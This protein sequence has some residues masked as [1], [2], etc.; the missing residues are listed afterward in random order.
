MPIG[1]SGRKV[2]Y[3]EV[4]IL[5]LHIDEMGVTWPTERMIAGFAFLPSLLNSGLEKPQTPRFR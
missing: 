5:P 4:G 1:I 3:P 2:A